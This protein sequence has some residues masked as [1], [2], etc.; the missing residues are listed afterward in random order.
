MDGGAWQARFHGWQNQTKLSNWHS[1]FFHLLFKLYPI[2][3]P[4]DTWGSRSKSGL[5]PPPLW[6]SWI[7][8][9]S[10]W[11]KVMLRSST[12]SLLNDSKLIS[13]LCSAVTKQNA[14]FL[15]SSPPCS[16]GSGD[17]GRT[18]RGHLWTV[19]PSAL[20]P[21]RSHLRRACPC[22]SWPTRC[23]VLKQRSLG[24]ALQ[25]CIMYFYRHPNLAEDLEKLVS[26]PLS[27]WSFLF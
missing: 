24:W 12:V 5:V 17:S 22:L 23:S 15:L 9:R 27:W 8:G 7:R 26:K 13:F 2:L 4:R 20:P 14:S 10:P 6:S 18:H 16:F 1:N 19:S 11:L 3:C 21:Q 25:V